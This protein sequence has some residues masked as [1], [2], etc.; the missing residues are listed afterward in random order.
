MDLVKVSD[1]LETVRGI[2]NQAVTI[3]VLMQEAAVDA[4]MFLLATL[5]NDQDMMSER[6]Q[7]LMR[8]LKEI[9]MKMLDSYK[10][11]LGILW[12]IITA[13]EGVFKRISNLIKAMCNFAKKVVSDRHIGLCGENHRCF[14]ASGPMGCRFVCA[15]KT[16]D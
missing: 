7:S 6:I 11:M 16:E 15:G 8:G 10:E 12:Q 1:F 5:A 2:V 4:L 13:E 14:Q 3:I 9:V